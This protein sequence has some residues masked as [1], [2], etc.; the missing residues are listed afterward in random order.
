MG[1][2]IDSQLEIITYLHIITEMALIKS[3]YGEKK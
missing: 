3:T 1:S 2:I